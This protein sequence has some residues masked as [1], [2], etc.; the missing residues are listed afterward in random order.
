VASAPIGAHP[1]LADIIVDRYR[2]AIDQPPGRTA[3][4]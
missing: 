4:A 3:P 2:S 1:A